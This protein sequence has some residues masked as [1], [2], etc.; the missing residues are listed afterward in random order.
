MFELYSSRA[1]VLKVQNNL[2][3]VYYEYLQVAISEIHN[4]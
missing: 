1:D 4:T 2:R 3:L